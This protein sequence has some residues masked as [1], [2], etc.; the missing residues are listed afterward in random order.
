MTS[1][2]LRTEQ[3]LL[4]TME[5]HRKQNLGLLLF[6]V[7]ITHGKYSLQDKPDCSTLSLPNKAD[8]LF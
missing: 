1:T 7:G 5:S 8:L 4:L 3:E 2:N 6:M